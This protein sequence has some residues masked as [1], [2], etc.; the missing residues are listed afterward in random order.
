[1]A[2]GLKAGLVPAVLAPIILTSMLLAA[3]PARAGNIES[4]AARA[5]AAESKGQFDDAVML[6]QS[7]VVAAPARAQGY[8]ALGDLYARHGDVQSAHKYYDEALYLEPGLPAALEGAGKADLALGDR[9][10]AQDKLERL[11]RVC[12]PDCPAAAKLNA[13]L[14]A[15]DK[16]GTDAASTSLDKP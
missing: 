8:V 5:K 1:M 14:A 2:F 15:A 6:L 11:A 10:A 9:K 13:A 12:G 4:L 7:A 16:T 3:G